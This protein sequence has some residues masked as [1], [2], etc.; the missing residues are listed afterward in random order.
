MQNNQIVNLSDNKLN[1]V[2][3]LR[4]ILRLAL[5]PREGT[6]WGGGRRG[7]KKQGSFQML[8]VIIQTIKSQRKPAFIQ[9]LPDQGV[10]KKVMCKGRSHFLF[11]FPHDP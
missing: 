1:G 11:N 7:R 5:L 6:A 9:Y 8:M 2:L 3:Y 4:V 10:P